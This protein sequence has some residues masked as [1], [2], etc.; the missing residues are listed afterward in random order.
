VSRG[1]RD[2]RL[3]FSLVNKKVV[4]HKLISPG[5]GDSRIVFE[6]ERTVPVKR[7]GHWRSR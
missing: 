4:N 2:I 3:D 5:E 6:C 7:R 1:H